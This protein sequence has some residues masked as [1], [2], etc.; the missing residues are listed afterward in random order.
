MYFRDEYLSE[1]KRH[2]GLIFGMYDYLVCSNY[3]TGDKNGSAP[4]VTC[5]T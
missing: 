1:T 5:F 4:G 2:R 3:G